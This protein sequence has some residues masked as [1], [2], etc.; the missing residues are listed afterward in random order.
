MAHGSA[1]VPTVAVILAALD[2]LVVYLRRTLPDRKELIEQL[3]RA[4]KELDRSLTNDEKRLMLHGKPG[5]SY[6]DI[7]C[8]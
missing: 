5:N 7:A 3:D 2:E 4:V 8:L 6:G 1:P